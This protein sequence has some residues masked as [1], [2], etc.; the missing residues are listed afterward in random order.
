MSKR[1]NKNSSNWNRLPFFFILKQNWEHKYWKSYIH[2]KKSKSKIYS[3]VKVFFLQN[4]SPS[5]ALNIS[6][7]LPCI[8]LPFL[9]EWCRYLERSLVLNLEAT[10]QKYWKVWRVQLAGWDLVVLVWLWLKNVLRPILY[11]ISYPLE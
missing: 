4:N 7:V 5:I 10:S 1:Y 8:F 9:P 6:T 3:N 11:K 2:T